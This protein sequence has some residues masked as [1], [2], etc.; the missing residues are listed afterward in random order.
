M[1]ELSQEDL[2]SIA[3]DGGNDKRHL[4]KMLWLWLSQIDNVSDVWQTLAEAV[5]AIR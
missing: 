2:D 3:A 4:R 5:E 1:L